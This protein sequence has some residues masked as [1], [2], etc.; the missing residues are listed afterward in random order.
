MVYKFFDKKYTVVL[1]MKLDKINNLQ[2]NFINQSSGKKRKV[3]SSFKDNIWG[4]DLA[5]MQLISKY[6]KGIRYLICTIDL[7]SKYA[8]IF[9]L[10]DKKIVSIVNAFQKII[11][12]SKRKPNKIQADQ[13]SEFYNSQF[14]EVLKENHMEKYSTYNEGKS[15]VAEKFI[16]TLKNKIYKHMTAVLKDFD[17]LDVIVDEYDNT[18]HKTIKIKPIDI[19]LDSYSVYNVE[20]N[21]KDPKF[22]A[23]D[24][25][26]IS[27]YEN[28]FAKVYTPNWYEEVFAI[29]KIKNTVPWTYVINDLNGEEIVGTS[30]ERELQKTDQIE[31]RIEKVIKRKGNKLFVKWKGYDN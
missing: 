20:S 25:V 1:Q 7:F 18:F 11:D 15:A 10:K 28:I 23:G 24:H 22:K 26:R 21:E 2:M 6:S 5:D 9:P 19:K 12:N 8:W 4:A 27:K 13:G 14:K 30:Y 29:S 31:L 16:K 17:V 3:Y